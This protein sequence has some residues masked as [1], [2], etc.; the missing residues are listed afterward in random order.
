VQRDGIFPTDD[1][2]AL[3]G[4]IL[5]DMALRIWEAQL[6]GLKKEFLKHGVEY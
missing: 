4:A 1:L 6:E 5:V 3:F 2:P